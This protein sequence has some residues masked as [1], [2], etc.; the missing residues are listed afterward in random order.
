[1]STAYH[2]VSS[3]VEKSYY[4]D[5]SIKEQIN[6]RVNIVFTMQ[7]AAI[8]LIGYFYKNIDFSGLLWA[9]AGV[10][11]LT[12]MALIIWLLSLRYSFKAFSDGYL[13]AI[14]PPANDILLYKKQL[15]MHDH[16]NSEKTLSEYLD[17]K[18]AE[19]SDCNS[20]LNIKRS[21][22]AATAISCLKYSAAL[23]LF[24]SIIFFS[25]TL[26]MSSERHKQNIISQQIKEF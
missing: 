5:L 7:L 3:L 6:S 12:G 23:L 17:M 26:D 18:F 19:C 24:S 4:H 10:S 22:L 13:Y 25:A 20:S 21:N 16:D 15:E 1:M 14:L 8:T 11:A 2:N 9:V